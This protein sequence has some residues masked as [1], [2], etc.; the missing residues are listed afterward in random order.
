MCAYVCDREEEGCYL[1][2]VGSNGFAVLDIIRDPEPEK[3]KSWL[4]F[5]SS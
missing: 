4:G 3:Q 5:A 1:F 2:Y